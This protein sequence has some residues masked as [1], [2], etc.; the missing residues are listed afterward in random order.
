MVILVVTMVI[1]VVTM[2][3]LVVTMVIV[4]V[5]MVI[6]V[7]T[8]VILVATMVIS[9]VRRATQPQQGE[10]R[11]VLPQDRESS[12]QRVQPAPHDTEQGGSDLYPELLRRLLREIF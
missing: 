12:T 10:R 11:E 9:G 2:V 1:L 4:V 3:I 7:V 8:M 6:V 5:T